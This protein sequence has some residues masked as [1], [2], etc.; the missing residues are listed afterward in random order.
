M[1]FSPIDPSRATGRVRTLFDA[2]AAKRGRVPRLIQVLGHSP[3]ALGMYL[4]AG[5]ALTQGVLSPAL[6]EQIALAVAQANGCATCLAAHSAFG[7][8]LG[9]SEAELT[10]AR[11]A[12]SVDPKA[13]VALEFA[14]RV[15]AAGGRIGAEEFRA[16]QA[17]GYTEAGILE[18]VA[19]VYLNAFA[20]AVNHLA[21]TE[22]DYPSVAELEPQDSA[23]R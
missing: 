22:P 16:V 20:N 21:E 7:R 5:A 15:L 17:A 11:R 18:I 8:E 12:E 13:Q 23:T 19:T 1:R 2:V 10:S 9:L 6:R 3:A 4:G 14:T